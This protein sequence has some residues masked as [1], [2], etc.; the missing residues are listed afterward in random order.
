MSAIKREVSRGFVDVAA[1]ETGMFRAIQQL[2][3][4][5]LL[6]A[7]SLWPYDGAPIDV[8]SMGF[9]RQASG[10]LRQ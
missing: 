4:F 1:L 9:K 10:I 7:N 8:G 6:H 2:R 3:V 5:K